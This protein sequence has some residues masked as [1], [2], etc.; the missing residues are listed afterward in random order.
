MGETW[1][2]NYNDE[3]ICC[4]LVLQDQILVQKEN[5]I[6]KTIYRVQEAIFSVHTKLNPCSHILLCIL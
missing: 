3:C 5:L 6:C 2:R 4:N 1:E